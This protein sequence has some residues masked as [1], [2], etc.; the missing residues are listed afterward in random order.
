MP[1]DV[2]KWGHLLGLLFLT[3]LL[4]NLFF[5]SQN[6]EESK[7]RFLKVEN[8]GKSDEQVLQS[9]S[10][11]S[12][13]EL[14]LPN[15]PV[16]FWREKLGSAVRPKEVWQL[17]GQF[18]SV[19][20]L[21]Y[22]NRFWQEVNTS[23][24]TFFLYGAYL[25]RRGN[26]SVRILGMFARPEQPSLAAFCQ[27]WFPNTTEPVVSQVEEYKQIYQFKILPKPFLLTC[28]IPE[29]H[30]N[31]APS[32]VS[33]V[34]QKCEVATTNLKVTYRP[35]GE[36]E[37]KE[38][39]AVCT[40]GIDFPND[41]S[42]RLAEWIELLTAL[43]ANRIFF[44]DLGVNKNVSHLLKHYSSKGRVGLTPF[45]LA[46]HQPN[47]P[48]L[49]HLYLKAKVGVNMQSELIPYNDCFY[50]NMLRLVCQQ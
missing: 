36:G 4:G 28:P 25:D 46:G 15:L 38:N 47:H 16:L 3:S 18:P 14:K 20:D 1:V 19:L 11:F 9:D 34:E 17:C 10:L 31:M 27:L 50:S 35:L 30:K 6:W 48:G 21:H 37:T 49:T 43:G 32:S 45:S 5:L 13:L 44:Y 26:S 40:K 22:N 2:Q 41:N 8:M 39:F 12:W 24:G 7:R 23:Q 33:L 29:S 42:P